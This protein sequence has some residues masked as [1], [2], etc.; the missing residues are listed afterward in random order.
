MTKSLPRNYQ[1]NVSGSLSS[2]FTDPY[3]SDASYGSYQLSPVILST[4]PLPELV[5]I[6]RSIIRDELQGIKSEETNEKLLNVK[7]V[8]KLLQISR[9]T[10]ANW[11]NSDKLVAHSVGGKKYYKYSEIMASIDKIK[12]YSRA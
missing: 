9:T 2:S 11:T 8:Q 5:N 1:Q 7:E 12:S 4:V 6:F 10:V 3:Y